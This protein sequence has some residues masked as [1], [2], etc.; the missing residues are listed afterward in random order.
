MHLLQ[1]PLEP[2]FDVF[3]RF[4]EPLAFE[5]NET[6]LGNSFFIAQCLLLRLLEIVA[7][8]LC[9]VHRVNAQELVQLP[10]NFDLLV[11]REQDLLA[12]LLLPLAF[13]LEL[14]AFDFPEFVQAGI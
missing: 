10:V 1:T 13:L 12:S 7:H 14:S 2:C 11:V 3:K 4:E 6:K 9:Q 5:S 8:T